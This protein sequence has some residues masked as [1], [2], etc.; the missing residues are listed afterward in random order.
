M[1]LLAAEALD[2]GDRQA[3]HADLA[4]RLAHFL[5]LERLDD[6]GDLFHGGLRS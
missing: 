1:T 2:L 3:G 5:E 4:E 6:G